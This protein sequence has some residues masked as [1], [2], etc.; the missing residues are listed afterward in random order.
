M[1]VVKHQ[2][3]TGNGYLILEKIIPD[4]L[5]DSILAKKELLYPVRASSSNK[6]YAER[7]EIEKLPNV[8][9]WWSQFVMDWPEVI[10]IEQLINPTV[11]MHLPKA[12][13]Y[14]SDIVTI[15]AGSTW[16]NPHVDTPHRFKKY[17]FNKN[18]LGIQAIV[19]LYDLDKTNGATGI[20]PKSQMVNYNIDFCY[21]GM[22]DGFFKANSIQP[23]LPKG[24][25]LLY[26][27]RV[28]HSS[29][30]N[31]TKQNRPALL[32]NYLDSSIIEDVRSLDNIWQSN[33]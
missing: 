22:Y 1:N 32:L 7:N 26:N 31:P 11:N 30:P 5:I 12:E 8:S 29:M 20:V 10:Q 14:A 17:N 16:I 15:N 33:G 2:L 9:V 23:S 21:Q 4:E 6:K 13:W 25:V 24:S 28:L 27:S 3:T 18:F 19:S